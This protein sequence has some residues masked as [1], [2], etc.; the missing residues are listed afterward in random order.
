MLA[1][2]S[3]RELG[4]SFGQ[5]VQFFVAEPEGKR[6]VV[7]GDDQHA[8]VEWRVALKIAGEPKLEVVEGVLEPIRPG[9]EQQWD[10]QQAD[11]KEISGSRADAQNGALRFLAHNPR[12]RLPE[13]LSV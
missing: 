7:E 8:G 2:N 5:G 4:E 11:Q 3:S 12:T 6:W 1:R 9:C 10:G 13:P